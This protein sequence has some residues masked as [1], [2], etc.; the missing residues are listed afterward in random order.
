MRSIAL[1]V[2]GLVALG[3]YGQQQATVGHLLIADSIQ[4]QG[5]WENEALLVNRIF[6][7]SYHKWNGDSI[8][9]TLLPAIFRER[10][11]L[12]EAQPDAA[13]KATVTYYYANG[14]FDLSNAMVFK[15]KRHETWKVI[16]DTMALTTPF[17]SMKTLAGDPMANSYLD[18]LINHELR[19]LFIRSREQGDSVFLSAFGIGVDSLKS[20]ALRRGETYL[21]IPL[22]ARK[23]PPYA[24]ERYLANQLL[25]NVEKKDL[26]LAEAVWQELVDHYP[27][28]GYLKDCSAALDKQRAALSAG[29]KNPDIVFL[30]NLDTL[31]SIEKLIEPFDGKVVYLDIWGTWCGPCVRELSQYTAALKQRFEGRDDLIFLYVATDSDSDRQKWEQFVR[32]HLITGYHARFTDQAMEPLWIDLDLLATRDVPR[33]YPTYAIFD[34]EGQLVTADAKRPSQGEALYLQLEEALTK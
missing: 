10:D 3:S 31:K 14:I 8:V 34:R 11:S 2:F 17:P 19:E 1:F 15:L 23:F 30:E 4:K 28:S 32:L 33:T 25:M 26:I 18:N 7:D 27:R 24:H 16:A 12:V 21:T 5:V 20:L 9:N 29:T 22:S 6:T 13:L